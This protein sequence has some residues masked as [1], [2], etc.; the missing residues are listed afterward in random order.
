MPADADSFSP[1]NRGAAFATTRWSVVLL[2]A[3]GGEGEAARHSLEA[4]CRSYWYP[5]Y[6]YVRR[7]GH[8]PEDAQ[9][10]T[11]GFFTFAL[12]KH[13]LAK[14]DPARG[15][16]RSFLL[17][18]VRNFLGNEWQKQHAAKR[19]GGVPLIPLDVALAEQRL[20]TEPATLD[21]PGSIYERA[22]AV[23]VIE[24]AL[25]RLSKEQASAGKTAVFEKLRP[26]LGGAPTATFAEIGAE[27][28][29]TEGA[30][31]VTLH[32]LRQRFRELLRASIA[33]TVEDP[34]EVEAELEHLRRVLSR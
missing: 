19:G 30:I 10:L 2:A 27:L 29:S 18:A 15:R 6:A 9:D 33:D 20:A 25:E 4:L 26:A 7:S 12:E 28:G 3:E 11:Q 13:L 17:G 23:S 32:R 22:W 14:A 31:R 5:I 16:F 1:S 24:L 8:G 34:R 21:D